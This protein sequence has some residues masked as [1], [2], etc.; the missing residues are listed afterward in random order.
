MAIITICTLPTCLLNRAQL[1]GEPTLCIFINAN[2]CS[3]DCFYLRQKA[4]TLQSCCNPDVRPD[5]KHS[6]GFWSLDGDWT[7]CESTVSIKNTDRQPARGPHHFCYLRHSQP[8]TYIQVKQPV[9]HASSV[10]HMKHLWDFWTHLA[11]SL[12]VLLYL[13][14]LSVSMCLESWVCSWSLRKLGC[15]PTTSL[16]L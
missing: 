5:L 7:P 12:P 13:K 8:I 11:L 15:E 9:Q 6:V 14:G 3:L 1:P 2:N 4:T 10:I 16:T